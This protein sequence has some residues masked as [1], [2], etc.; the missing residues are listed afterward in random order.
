M[1]DHFT[2]GSRFRI[3]AVVDDSTRE[4]LALVEDTSMSGMRLTRELSRI[5]ATRGLPETIVP[6]NGKEVTSIA[7]PN[8]CQ[9]T[10]V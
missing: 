8:W 3:L 6:D 1:S 10:G 2:D 5:V 7:V 9:E 4:N